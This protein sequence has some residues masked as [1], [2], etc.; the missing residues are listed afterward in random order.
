MKKINK[1]VCFLFSILILLSFFACQTVNRETSAIKLK[2]EYPSCYIGQQYDA[3]NLIVKEDGW[4][5]S[6][7]I[8][9]IEGTQKV[10][11]TTNGTLF[12]AT[13]KC[14]LKIKITA[15]N[16][17]NTFSTG[18]IDLIVTDKASPQVSPQPTVPATPQPTGTPEISDDMTDSEYVYS[19]ATDNYGV[20]STLTLQTQVKSPLNENALKT[21]IPS[22]SNYSTGYES[23]CDVW[24]WICFPLDNI[25]NVVSYDLSTKYMKYYVKLDN[26]CL[27]NSFIL[28]DNNG[29]YSNEYGMSIADS[30]RASYYYVKE[31]DDGWFCIYLKFSV[32][33]ED[34]F[35]QRT[36]L[37]GTKFD[38]THCKTILITTSNSQKNTLIP[39]NIWLTKLMIPASSF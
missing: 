26:A 25:K 13:K 23:N 20:K 32:V 9:F 16:Q 12:T 37:S 18:L 5:Y 21:V 7:E 31:L 38:I 29:V 10:Y 4:D 14:T 36:Y 1:A 33:R 24:S 15:D 30:S 28:E 19:I 8:Y 17:R 2:S 35:S 22:R 3:L 39:A 6:A 27:T 34:T 11:I